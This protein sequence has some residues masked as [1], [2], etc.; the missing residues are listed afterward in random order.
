MQLLNTIR[1]F[2]WIDIFVVILLIRTGYIAIR[3]GLPIEFFKLLGTV[4]AVYAAMHYYLSLA[5]LFGGSFPAL[6]F[7]ALA[8]FTYFIFV[9]LRT[10]FYRFI[11]MEAVPRFNQWGGFII[12]I[13]R[14][15][16]FISLMMF[17]FII[18]PGSYFK[19]SVRDAY[20]GKYFV[21]L[22]PA[23]YSKLWNGI[24][25]KFM[26]QEKINQTVNETVSSL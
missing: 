20:S 4:A 8:L 22:A 3:N 6:V 24:F 7:I 21:P 25:S 13:T 26:P 17:I 10:L 18:L 5:N 14:G 19:N 9:I 1:Q 2:N 11:K 12:G 15:I 23:T 16:L